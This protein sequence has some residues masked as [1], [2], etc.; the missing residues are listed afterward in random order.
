VKPGDH[1]VYCGPTDGP[2]FP[3][4]EVGIV[5]HAHAPRAAVK[6]QWGVHYLK[7]EH[8]RVLSAQLEEAA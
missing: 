8:L 5:L 6:F 1:V 4:Q 7:V 2:Y 3:A